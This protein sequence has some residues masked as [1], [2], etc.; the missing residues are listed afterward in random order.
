MP[1]RA[2]LVLV[3]V[4]IAGFAGSGPDSWASRQRPVTKERVE[5]IW[6][7]LS[8]DELYMVRLDLRPTGR[9]SCAFSFRD[10]EACLLR[11]R[12]WVYRNGVVQI[13][14]DQPTCAAELALDGVIQ[15][16]ILIVTMK[17]H[18]WK[19]T[20]ELRREGEFVSRWERLK[21]VMTD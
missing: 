15:G 5:K 14:H 8:E 7:G 19:R 12:S 3:L 1:P 2:L 17:G 6:I 16:D 10:E 20:A 18:R 9:G 21:A 11:I 13:E 4:V